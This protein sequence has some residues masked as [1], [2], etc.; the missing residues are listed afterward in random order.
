MCGVQIPTEFIA[1]NKVQIALKKLWTYL[2]FILNTIADCATYPWLA[3]NREERELSFKSYG[4]VEKNVAQP[5]R[6][7]LSTSHLPLP[8]K[9]KSTHDPFVVFL[10]YH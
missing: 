6:N 10:Q 1:Y 7:Q 5:Y 4:G 8:I 3:K 9:L 2:F